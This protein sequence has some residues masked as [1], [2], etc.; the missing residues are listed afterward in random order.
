MTRGLLINSNSVVQ[1]PLINGEFRNPSIF[2]CSFGFYISPLIPCFDVSHTFAAVRGFD[3][4][5]PISVG[6]SRRIDD[7]KLVTEHVDESCQG[8]VNWSGENFFACAAFR[9]PSQQANGRHAESRAVIDP[10]KRNLPRD[11]EA[12][13]ASTFSRARN[14]V[15]QYRR[16]RVRG[17]G[18]R[19]RTQRSAA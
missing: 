6:L 2:R 11:S 8:R 3:A 14:Y 10:E 9:A 4:R 13:E 17:E 12:Y 5:C 16:E 19:W 15:K 7:R 1:S 18:E